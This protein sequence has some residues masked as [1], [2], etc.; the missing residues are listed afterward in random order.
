MGADV[1]GCPAVE[2]RRNIL[3]KTDFRIKRGECV[4]GRRDDRSALAGCGAWSATV[5][6][7]ERI[8]ASRNLYCCSALVSSLVIRPSMRASASMMVLSFSTSV[9][10]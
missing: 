7:S 2:V 10:R 6:V 1:D 5:A 4:G 8:S 9:C 3:Q